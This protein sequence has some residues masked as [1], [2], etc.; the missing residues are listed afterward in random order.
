M[1]VR[2]ELFG[3]GADSPHLELAGW[4]V[5]LRVVGMQRMTLKDFEQKV[6]RKNSFDRYWYY[7]ISILVIVLSLILLFLI[8]TKPYKF[9]GNHAFH[10]SGF[11]FLFLLGTYALY[12]LPNRYKVITIKSTKPLNIKKEILDSVVEYFGSIPLFSDDNYY[13]FLYYR[14]WWRSSYDIHL[15]YDEKQISYSVQG[16]SSGDGGFLDLGGTERLR[17]RIKEE[18]EV[19]LN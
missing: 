19:R 4:F 2:P 6:K 16:R 15:F 13:S 18:I 17:N 10:Y 1:T 9:N 14:S 7:G 5:Y 12:K 11:L 3:L 8:F